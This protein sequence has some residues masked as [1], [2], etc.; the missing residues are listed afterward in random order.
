[1]YCLFATF[2]T[3]H[4]QGA[5]SAAMSLFK[6][7]ISKAVKDAMQACRSRP[8]CC[9]FDCCASSDSQ[10]G[11]EQ[12]PSSRLFW[13]LAGWRSSNKQSSYH[14]QLSSKFVSTNEN[15]KDS[16]CI[17]N[18]QDSSRSGEKVSPCTPNSTVQTRAQQQLEEEEE[19]DTVEGYLPRQ[20]EDYTFEDEVEDVEDTDSDL[21]RAANGSPPVSL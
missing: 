16:S 20:R 15:R 2:T 13:T 14:V 7:D 21:Q 10:I 1:M 6:P 12:P 3:G 17:G 8:F 9:V 11:Q 18:G 4:L 5:V 19:E